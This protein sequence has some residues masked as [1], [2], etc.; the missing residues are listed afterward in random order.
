MYWAV[1]YGGYRYAAYNGYPVDLIVK[2]GY[3]S[4]YNTP[5]ATDIYNSSN[6]NNQW[7]YYGM[8]AGWF[9]RGDANLLFTGKNVHGVAGAATVGS[10]C[11]PYAY[12]FVKYL[13]N[14]YQEQNTV[15]HEIGH[16]LGANHSNDG[17]MR[18]IGTHYMGQTTRNELNYWLS[19]N[20]SCLY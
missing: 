18:H 6:F 5:V 3:L 16:I 20:N 12:G 14:S 15:A 8:S 10:I 7:M 17:F 9:N 2:S 19:W 4:T 11:G 13:Y 1:V